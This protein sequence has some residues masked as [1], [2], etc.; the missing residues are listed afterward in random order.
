MIRSI[1][2]ALLLT[3]VVACGDDG[4]NEPTLL[5]NGAACQADNE[6]EVCTDPAFCLEEFE[7]GVELAG[8]MCTDECAWGENPGDPDTCGD[9]EV[10]LRYNPTQE[11]VCFQECSSDAD[12][13]EDDGWSCLCLD[14]FCSTS[15]CVPELSEPASRTVPE[16][17]FLEH[18]ALLY[19][20]AY[21]AL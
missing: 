15:A 4:K 18:P 6:D 13:R 16:D 20:T 3:L 11:Y 12:C 17:D 9:G 21:E 2:P 5:E 14:F 19:D 10:C 8:G 7:N 1:I